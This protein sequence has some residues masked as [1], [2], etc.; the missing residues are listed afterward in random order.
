MPQTARC[1]G[2]VGLFNCMYNT[3][4]IE[5][6]VLCAVDRLKQGHMLVSDC[7]RSIASFSYPSLCIITNLNDVWWDFMELYLREIRFLCF[8]PVCA[9]S[10]TL[11]VFQMYDYS[12]DM[13][14]LGCMLASMIFR[15]EPF[16]HG[17]DN[18]DQVNTNQGCLMGLNCTTGHRQPLNLHGYVFGHTVA[19]LL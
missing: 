7:Q 6:L 11:C 19:T 1:W 15:K 17:H 18:Y 4:S 14:S 5:S 16:F 8:H 10:E 3:S 12:L 9:P 13:W 2:I